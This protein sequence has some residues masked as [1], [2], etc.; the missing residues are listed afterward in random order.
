MDVEPKLPATPMRSVTPPTTDDRGSKV[1]IPTDP[2]NSTGAPQTLNDSGTS[3]S[4][5]RI[6]RHFHVFH[7]RCSPVRFTP[8]KR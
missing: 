8:S 2:I 7:Q 4:V 3:L 1:R 6:P 5:P